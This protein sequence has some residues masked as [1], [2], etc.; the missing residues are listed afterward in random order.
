[1]IA[2]IEAFGFKLIRSFLK[3][4]CPL[5][6]VSQQMIQKCGHVSLDGLADGACLCTK[7]FK[8]KFLESVG[9]NPKTYARIIRLNRAYNI[10]NAYP[11]RDW[12]GIAIE[13]GY[14]DYQHLAK[15]YKEFAGVTPNEFYFLESRSPERVLGLTDTIYQERVGL[16]T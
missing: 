4:K 15:D 9:V 16:F 5:D 1:M 11:D 3:D 6:V 10:K 7:Q 8:R 13:C 12:L 2:I 14:Y